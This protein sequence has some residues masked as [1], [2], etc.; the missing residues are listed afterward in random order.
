MTTE[1]PALDVVI[2]NHNT[3]DDVLACLESLFR[4]PPRS[5]ART[6]VVDTASTDG[7]AAAIRAAWP[8]VELLALGENPGFAAANNHALRATRAPLV[9]LLN[10]DT[11]VPPGAVDALVDRLVAV[12]AAAAGPRLEDG[13]GRPEVSFGRM[14]TPMSE[15]AQA[16]KTRLAGSASALARRVVERLVSRE[17]IV[18]WVSAACLLVR[19]DAAAAVGFFDERYFLYEEDVDFCAALRATGGRILFTPR[20]RVIHVRGRSTAT[21]P[22]ARTAY[23]DR[24]HVAFYEKHAPAW[25]PVLRLWLRLRGRPTSGHS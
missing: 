11:I 23:Y 17:R 19:R 3:K 10:S 2:V 20:A 12:G 24:S 16:L 8:A 6:F 14:L 22:G 9:L 4:N 7:S 18:D 25:A 21:V 1:R 13:R 15:A 5:L